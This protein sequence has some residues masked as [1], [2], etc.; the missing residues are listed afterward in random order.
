MLHDGGIPCVRLSADFPGN[1]AGRAILK[2]KTLTESELVLVVGA[3][4][5]ALPVSSLPLGGYRPPTSVP[6]PEHPADVT[7]RHVDN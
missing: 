3:S 5:P 2:M 7:P 1:S 6:L 4:D